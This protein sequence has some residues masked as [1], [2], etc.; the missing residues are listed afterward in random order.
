MHHSVPFHKNVHDPPE[1]SIVHAVTANSPTKPPSTVGCSQ[2]HG[3]GERELELLELELELLE[4][5]LELDDELELELELDDGL[6][7]ELELEEL[8]EL[9]ELDDEEEEDDPRQQQIPTAPILDLADF[10]S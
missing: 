6:E 9:L 7:L 3:L 10:E 1:H 5:E 2:L 8:D 4:L